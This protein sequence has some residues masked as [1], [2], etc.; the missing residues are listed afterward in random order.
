VIDADKYLSFCTGPRQEEL[1]RAISQSS[2]IQEG[3]ERAGI[4]T[5]NGRRMWALVRER[6]AAGG[7]A[8]GHFESG[9]APGFGMGKVTIQRGKEG[10]IER[11]W[12]RQHPKFQP[13]CEA[14]AQ[15]SEGL[16]SGME[17]AKPA[18]EG[19]GKKYVDDLMTAIFIGDAHVGMRAYGKE[20][21]HHDFD[22]GIAVKQ[23]RDAADYLVDKAVPTETGLLVDVGDFQHANGHNNSTFAGTPLDVDTRHR[24]T[25]YEAAMVMRYI[26]DKMLTKHKKVVVVVAKGNHNEDVAPAI[27]LMLSFY[28]EREPRVKVLETHGH[29]HY[30]E[31]GKWLLGVCHGDKQ[32]AESL[33]ASMARDM[34]EAWGRTTHRMWCTG[35]FHKEAVKTLPGCKHKIFAALPPP[36]SWHASH[37][38]SGDGEMEML[39]F[40]KAGGLYSSHVYNIPRP[41]I[42]PD[43]VI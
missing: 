21:K 8:P 15:F 31:Y 34:S 22:T 2:S 30:I 39:T 7:Y 20:T 43:V 18:K 19:K 28:Y 11:V 26:I 24:S 23:L 33:V 27:E 3:I 17:Q 1:V 40:R 36:D 25:M 35:H 14:L 12:E 4:N 41:I 32:K 5:R 38:F 9:V 6:A 37:G 42:Q 10:E 13:L 29:Y 16:Q